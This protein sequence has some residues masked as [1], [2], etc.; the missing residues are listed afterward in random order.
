MVTRLDLQLTLFLS[1]CF[2]FLCELEVRPQIITEGERIPGSRILLSGVL[3]SKIEPPLKE[4][5]NPE[6]PSD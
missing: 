2:H 4:E 6:E 1:L 3:W 5:K